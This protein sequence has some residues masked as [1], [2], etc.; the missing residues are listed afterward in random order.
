MF[1]FRTDMADE[2]HDI[3]KKANHLENIPGIE[4]T[5]NIINDNVV[6]NPVFQ[7]IKSDLD[8]N[9]SSKLHVF[10][11]PTNDQIIEQVNSLLKM[12]PLEPN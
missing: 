12:L 3:Y 9:P 1:N 4:T 11:E 6:N 8:S 2:R 10:L 5:E 7:K